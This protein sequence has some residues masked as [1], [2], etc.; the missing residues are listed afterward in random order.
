MYYAGKTNGLVD[1]WIANIIGF[2]INQISGNEVNG[3]ISSLPG[4]LSEGAGT[5]A[6]EN[7][8]LK[9]IEPIR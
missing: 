7:S 9:I 1:L 5:V 8:F 3:Y 4:L 2:F 6:P